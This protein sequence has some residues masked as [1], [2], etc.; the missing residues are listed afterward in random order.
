[1]P[2]TYTWRL[3]VRTYE[4]DQFGHVNNTVYPNWLEEAATRASADAGY[5]LEWYLDRGYYWLVRKWTIRYLQPAFY[6]DELDITT[7]VSAFHRVHSPREYV[8]TRVSDGAKILRARTDWAFVDTKDYRLTRIPDELKVDFAPSNE[9]L[10]DLGLRIRNAEPTV[11]AHRYITY[12]DVEFSEIDLA[13]HVNNTVYLRWIEN[14]YQRAMEAANWSFQ[15]Q[16]KSHNIL[17]YSGG[18]EIEYFKPA[19]YGDRIKVVSWVTEMARVRGAW[20]HEVRHA[21]TDELLA[22]D[23]AVGLFVDI[24]GDQPKPC[25]LPQSLVDAVLS[26][27]PD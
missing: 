23:Y 18:H 15:R 8:V 22:R 14:A 25:R 16:W 5:P 7:W 3:Q 1:M 13:G 4:I 12:R 9:P 27:V 19:R 2:R 10:E 21:E 11:N 26:G 6:G 24:S 17:I 20:I